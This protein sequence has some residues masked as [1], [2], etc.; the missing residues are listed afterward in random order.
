MGENNVMISIKAVQ[1]LPDQDGDSMELMTSGTLEQEGDSFTLSYQ[2]TE[3][4]GMEGTLTT[5]HIEKDHISLV[6]LG[7]FNT[8]ML[9][10]QGRRTLSVYDT[11]YGAMDVGVNTRS[12]CYDVGVTGGEIT[13]VYDIE[14]NHSVQSSNMFEISIRPLPGVQTGT[15]AS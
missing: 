8:T 11:P 9:F 12:M 2:E 13:I 5:F 4:T 14:I 15:A 6:R 7:Q 3:V 1:A 10:E